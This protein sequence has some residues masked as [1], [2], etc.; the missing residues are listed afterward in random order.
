MKK[1]QKLNGGSHKKEM[2]PNDIKIDF[3]ISYTLKVVMVFDQGIEK[4][5]QDIE[6]I[7][8]RQKIPFEFQSIKKSSNSNYISFS[9][10]ITLLSK[11]QMDDLYTDL[12]MLPGIKIA[13]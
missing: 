13:I 1:S 4:H 8:L 10:R 3:P 7:L 5:Q 6:E 12:K 2:V 9:I 11:V